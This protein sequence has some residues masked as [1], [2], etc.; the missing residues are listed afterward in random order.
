MTISK[1]SL[2]TNLNYT[3]ETCASLDDWSAIHTT[4]EVSNASQLIVRDNFNTTDAARR[5]IRLR[6]ATVP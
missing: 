1:N 2:A 3:V 4:V 5:F 6:V